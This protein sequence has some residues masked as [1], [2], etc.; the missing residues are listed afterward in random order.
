MPSGGFARRRRKKRE[1]RAPKIATNPTIQAATINGDGKEEA[2]ATE[3]GFVTEAGCGRTGM[4]DVWRALATTISL[5]AVAKRKSSSAM[6]GF[7]IFPPFSNPFFAV[8]SF[9]VNVS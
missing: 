7:F 1:R 9:V 5:N 8:K 6:R 2:F 3:T 4:W